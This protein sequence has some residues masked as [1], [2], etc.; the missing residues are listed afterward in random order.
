VRPPNFVC[1]DIRKQY[2]LLDMHAPA[3]P[4]PSTPRTVCMSAFSA[5]ALFYF[6]FEGSRNHHFA[7]SCQC[8]AAHFA[9]YSSERMPL[10]TFKITRICLLIFCAES[11]KREKIT[12]Q[13]QH[14]KNLLAD[15]GIFWSL[16][17]LKIPHPSC[18][19]NWKK[20]VLMLCS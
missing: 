19:G 14:F 15:R 10:H 12:A 20:C 4:H 3:S 7:R 5:N 11:P 18:I 9:A 8:I 16:R 1:N 6:P 2:S 17:I 13:I